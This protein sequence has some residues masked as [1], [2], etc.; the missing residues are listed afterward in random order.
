MCARRISGVH[1]CA[2]IKTTTVM[3][4]AAVCCAIFVKDLS[5]DLR[6]G[7][8][9]SV[10]RSAPY[11]SDVSITGPPF[12]LA[13]HC[14]SLEAWEACTQ[15]GIIEREI[16][17]VLKANVQMSKMNER[18]FSLHLHEP[19]S[20][21]AANKPSAVLIAAL[22]FILSTSNLRTY[23]KTDFFRWSL[24]SLQNFFEKKNKHQDCYMLTFSLSL[25]VSSLFCR[26][27]QCM[28][29]V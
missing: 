26:T 19:F 28:R 24:L 2:F 20:R 16:L 8:V 23:S 22:F 27:T 12:V 17:S 11:A 10:F 21:K 6:Q 15:Q 3:A 25:G 7:P 5:K 14:R 18:R 29:G 1:V 4:W 9:T 13:K